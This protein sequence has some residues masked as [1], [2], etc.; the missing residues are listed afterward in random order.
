MDPLWGLGEQNHGWL[1]ARRDCVW[2]LGASRQRA[3]VSEEMQHCYDEV[4]LSAQGKGC[5]EGRDGVAPPNH[6][7]DAPSRRLGAN[8]RQ[9]RHANWNGLRQLNDLGDE[10]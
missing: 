3:D 10:C 5:L 4:F 2:H 8:S 6:G 9:S 1:A 7:L